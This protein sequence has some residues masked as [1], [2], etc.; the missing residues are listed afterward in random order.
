[1]EICVPGL[2][3]NLMRAFNSDIG[4]SEYFSYVGHS[5]TVEQA[6]AVIG[7]LAPDFVARENCIFWRADASSYDPV[8][9]P[10]IGMTLDASDQLVTSNEKRDIERYRNNFPINQFFSRWEGTAD[11]PVFKVG[12][13][14]DDYRLCHTFAKQIEQ[15]WQR[16]L[17]RCFPNKSF[18]FEIA[19]D[20]LD[21]YGVCVTFWEVF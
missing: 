14:E 9:Y 3:K 10:M 15:H 4:A 18:Q 20:L 5:V 11:R 19:D 12:L 2:D 13:G 21:E 8:K 7:I 6:I 1:M 16:A 17:L